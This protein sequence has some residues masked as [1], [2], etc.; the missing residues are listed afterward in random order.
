MSAPYHVLL[1]IVTAPNGMRILLEN[2]TGPI[3]SAPT[4]TRSAN[5][6]SSRLPMS[7]CGIAP[8]QDRK[9]A[10]GI[11]KKISPSFAPTFELPKSFASGLSASSGT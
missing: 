5:E 9:R 6:L 3:W 1:V 8:T 4:L 10:F 11:F 7:F 2:P